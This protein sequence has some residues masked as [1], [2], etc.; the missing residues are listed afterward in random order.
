MIEFTKRKVMGMTVHLSESVLV[1]Y[2]TVKQSNTQVEKYVI[3]KNKENKL[4]EVGVWDTVL[5]KYNTDI[6]SNCNSLKLNE[7]ILNLVNQVQK[8]GR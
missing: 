3:I 6:H 7:T 2:S 1:P 8:S 4:F 5:S